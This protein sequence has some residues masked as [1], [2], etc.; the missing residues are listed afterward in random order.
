[1]VK[2]YIGVHLKPQKVKTKVN[3]EINAY[4]P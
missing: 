3:Q 4:S 1:M 2:L